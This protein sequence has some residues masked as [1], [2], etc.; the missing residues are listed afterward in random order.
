[1]NLLRRFLRH[2]LAHNALGLYG[3]QIAGYVIPLVILPFVARVLGT[4]EFGLLLFAQSFASGAALTIEYGFN[5]SAT[6]EIAQHRDDKK[7]LSEI[8]AGVLG[9]KLALFSIFALVAG[10]IG[11]CVPNFRENP[12]YLLWA[13]AQ[14]LALGFSPFW[15]FQG[16]ERMVR[17]LSAEVLCRLSAAGL[18]FAVVRQP[19]D[20]WKVLAFQALA[21]CVSTFVPMLWLYREIEFRLPTKAG[22]AHALRSGWEMFLFR[23]AYSIYSTANAFILGLFVTPIYVGYF[24]GAQRIARAVQSLT[25]PLTQALYPRMSHMVSESKTK[26]ARWAR[27]SVSANFGG[28][29]LVSVVLA[30]TARW[31]VATGLGRGYEAS[32]PVLYIFALFL[33][34]N[35]VNSALI[36][37]WMLPLGMEKIVGR[38]TVGAIAINL[39]MATILAPRF[40]HIG[41]AWVMLAAECFKLTALVLLLVRRKLSPVN[42]VRPEETPSLEPM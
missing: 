28:A 6:R 1:M 5:L 2:P 12:L 22:I 34:V 9:A 17:A 41:M 15:Y 23:S 31:V 37:H 14:T 10:V 36:M 39:S 32:V 40:A 11:L 25:V 19:T 27:I 21:G 18:I 24:G 4:K 35:A 30:L 33:P 8:A 42:L 13:L 3:V 38:I 26:A 20:G 29:I 7:R 16:T